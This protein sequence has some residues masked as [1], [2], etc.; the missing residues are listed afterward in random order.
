MQIPTRYLRWLPI[1]ATGALAAYLAFTTQTVP[2]A[3]SAIVTAILF[4]TLKP[5][6][7]P[8]LHGD[9]A[10]WN[11]YAMHEDGREFGART[12]DG[13]AA[14]DIQ[15]EEMNDLNGHPSKIYYIKNRR[16]MIDLTRL[17]PWIQD[18]KDSGHVEHLLTSVEWRVIG[19]FRTYVNKKIRQ[20]SAA[21]IREFMN[22][23]DEDEFKREIGHGLRQKAAAQPKNMRIIPSIPQTE[24]VSE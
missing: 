23:I 10:L 2:A 18:M 14:K 7:G 9:V 3:A 5:D 6:A 11:H 19:Q 4:F 15:V 12:I 20:A 8:L 1:A 22:T 17:D 13:I 21:N 16:G 24:Q